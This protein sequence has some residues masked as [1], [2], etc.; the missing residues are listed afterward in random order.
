M[1][2]DLGML[3]LVVV[4]SGSVSGSSGGWLLVVLGACCSPGFAVNVKVPS[5]R[6]V[7]GV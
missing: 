5:A 2:L 7:G 3:G 4:A 1:G 6:G